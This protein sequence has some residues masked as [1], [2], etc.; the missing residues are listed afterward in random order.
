MEKTLCKTTAHM[1]T[2]IEINTTGARQS[3]WGEIFDN[4]P[5]KFVM[6]SPQRFQMIQSVSNRFQKFK[7]R[8]QN[9]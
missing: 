5:A 1:S 9:I 8:I 2:K 4:E 6:G 7:N 3:I